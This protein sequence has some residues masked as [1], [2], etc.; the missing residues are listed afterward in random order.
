MKALSY[1]SFF[2]SPADVP[3][4]L[5]YGCGGENCFCDVLRTAERG[6]SEEATSGHKQPRRSFKQP[7]LESLDMASTA[8]R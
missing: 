8:L 2:L 6:W 7:L 1:P 5:L 4:R 3:S